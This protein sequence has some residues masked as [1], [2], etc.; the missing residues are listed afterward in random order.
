MLTT[1]PQL[2]SKTKPGEKRDILE[3]KVPVAV[4]RQKSDDVKN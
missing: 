3:Q 2:R 4:K 1:D